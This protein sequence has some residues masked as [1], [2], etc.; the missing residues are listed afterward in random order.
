MWS[1][2]RPRRSRSKR[3]NHWSDTAS[4]SCRCAPGLQKRR[5]FAQFLSRGKRTLLDAYEH[6]TY[7]Y[8][9][10]VRK[11]GIPRDPSRLPLIEVQFNLERVGAILDFA[12]LKAEMDSCA[13][14]Y[15]NFDLFLNIVESED[16]LVMDCDYNTDLFDQATVSRWLG[17]YETL[18]AGIAQDM[19]RPL[20]RLPLLQPREIQE[21]VADRN[22]TDAAYPNRCVHELFEQQAASTPN[23]VAV[24]F[25]R[26]TLTY[27]ELHARSAEL[28][29]FLQKQGVGPGQLV[30][31][32]L[33]RSAEMVI[34]ILGV[35]KTGGAYVP[36]DPSYPKERLDFILGDA[37][38]KVLLTQERTAPGLTGFKAR[39]ICMDSERA[40]IARE[41]SNEKHAATPDDLS[42]RDLHLRVDRK[43]ERCRDTASR[44]GEFP[45]VDRAA[46]G[47]SAERPSAGRDDAFVRH[48]GPGDSAP[49]GLRRARRD[50]SP[51][52]DYGW[53][54]SGGADPGVRC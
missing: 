17:H 34:A 6:Q 11:L 3:A 16:G 38:A 23:A 43:T 1:A 18:L 46:A 20:R 4:T 42:L 37:G 28:A 45:D 8:G 10:L 29:A 52:V 5:R 32:C 53:D 33:E 22:Q 54:T 12:G 25:G 14:R 41:K 21:L 51:G 24:V 2:F 44:G 30:G 31:I 9:T 19:N 26:E 39:V 47:G 40:L 13:K 35:L 36:L 7:T 49:T 48:R 50:R 15:V 27:S